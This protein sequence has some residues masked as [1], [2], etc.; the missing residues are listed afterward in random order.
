MLPGGQQLTEPGHIESRSGRSMRGMPELYAH[1][2]VAAF[3]VELANIVFFQE[4]DQFLQ[5]LNFIRRHESL[6]CFNTMASEL[7]PTGGCRCQNLPTLLRNG[8]HILDADSKVICNVDA[9]L[10]GN[11]HSRQK[12][13]R[14]VR[15]NAGCFMNFQPNAMAGGVRKVLSQ[16]S[17]AKDAAR[18]FVYLSTGSP[19]LDRRNGSLLRL[20]HS[21]IREALPARWLAQENGA[22][23]V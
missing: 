9:G 16:S 20:P 22:R 15:G 1:L 12:G 23:H 11:H 4:L 5:L 13:L 17:F 7:R 6:V 3:E 2:E 8:N 14:L 10:D 19:R 21:I 18:C